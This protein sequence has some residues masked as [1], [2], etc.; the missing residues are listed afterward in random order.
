[1]TPNKAVNR[2][3][4][5]ADEAHWLVQIELAGIA[6]QKML[7]MRLNKADLLVLAKHYKIAMPE[8]F[9][10]PHEYKHGGKEELCLEIAEKMLT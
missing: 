4:D 10:E 6:K 8:I 9:V 2:I 7:L 5:D 1:M 3:D